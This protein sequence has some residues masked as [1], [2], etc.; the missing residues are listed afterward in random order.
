MS[1]KNAT[2]S[3]VN[4]ANNAVNALSRSQKGI[5]GIKA[6]FEGVASAL[7]M[8]T[9]ALGIFAGGLGAIAAVGIGYSI[10]NAYQQNLQQ[11]VDNANAASNELNSKNASQIGRAHV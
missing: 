4:D 11:A 10:Y 2:A 6:G 9:K 3:S 1:L 5:K 8:S 7:G